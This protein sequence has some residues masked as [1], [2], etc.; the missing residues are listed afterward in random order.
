MLL[1]MKSPEFF[2]DGQL[3]QRR[4]LLNENLRVDNDLVRKSGRWLN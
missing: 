1:L 2:Q 3:N 4:F